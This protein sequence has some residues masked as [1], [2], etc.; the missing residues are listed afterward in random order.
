MQCCEYSVMNMDM[1]YQLFVVV[2]KKN[3]ICSHS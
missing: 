3:Q 2:K 1:M